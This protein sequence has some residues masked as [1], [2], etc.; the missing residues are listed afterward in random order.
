MFQLKLTLGVNLKIFEIL[1]YV[2]RSY[3]VKSNRFQL[4]PKY[5]SKT[6]L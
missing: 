3:N 6:P 4:Q 1:V 5:F 2:K